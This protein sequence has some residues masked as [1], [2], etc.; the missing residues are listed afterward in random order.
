M[1][2]TFTLKFASGAQKQAFAQAVMLSKAQSMP[3]GGVAAPS[4]DVTWMGAGAFGTGRRG[5][6]F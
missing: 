4:A 1:G 5:M 2:E 6:G 3:A